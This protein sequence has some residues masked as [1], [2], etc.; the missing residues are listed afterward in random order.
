M[1]TVYSG[2]IRTP[3]MEA[4]SKQTTDAVRAKILMGFAAGP[5]DIAY[6]MLFLAELWFVTGTDTDIIIDGGYTAH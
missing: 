4:F 1:N 5:I 6:G 2:L 3:I